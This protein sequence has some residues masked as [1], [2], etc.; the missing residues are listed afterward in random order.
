MPSFWE[1]VR[2]L[3][4][5]K[6]G[7]SVRTSLD[8]F[9][10]IYGGRTSKSGVAIT[11]QRAIEATTV[12]ACT[13][14]LADGVAQVPFKLMQEGAD[15]KR[16]AAVD[17]PLYLLLHR[18]P[19][20]YQTAYEFRE[21]MMFH[22]ALAGDA[23]V[24][25]NRVGMER[26]VTEMV[27]LDPGRVEVKVKPDYTLHYRVRSDNGEPKD[28]PPG[29]IWHIRGPSWNTWRGL[30]GVKLLREAIGL[31]VA[32]E[33]DQ[34]EFHKNGAQVSGLLS[35]EN[36]LS[37]DKY[38]EIA[39]WID[40]HAPGG[41]RHLKPMILDLGA[42]FAAMRMTSV[43]AQHL[44]SRKFQVEEVCRGM[45]IMPLMI[46]H[47]AD[48]A[49]RAATESIFLAHVTHSL[50]P[51][52]SRIE[53]SAEVNLLT[54]ADVKAGLYVKFFAQALMRGASKERAEYYAKALGSG[55]AKGWMTQNEVRAL[56]D[57]D[58]HDDPEADKLPQP[59]PPKPPVDSGGDAADPPADPKDDE[60]EED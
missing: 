14:V 30:E 29:S 33:E 19:N 15:G 8:L 9:R 5:I 37:P 1:R 26:R 41:E 34:A 3:V 48:M 45:R 28:M 42:K 31:G 36:N 53:Q 6:D 59:A 38:K 17:H 57:Q 40:K 60:E 54:E 58:R 35:V 16:Q 23:F 50:M 12:L 49:A 2:S 47:P 4:G 7:G 10:E 46:G 21:T 52:Y 39:A 32:L 55:G 25:L 13:R 43:D 24:F 22:L 11:W 20:A 44:E 27:L 51:W 18:R 56:E